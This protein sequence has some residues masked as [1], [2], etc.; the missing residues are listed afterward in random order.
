MKKCGIETASK[1]EEETSASGEEES[2]QRN[3]NERKA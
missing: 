1:S 3:I 2:R